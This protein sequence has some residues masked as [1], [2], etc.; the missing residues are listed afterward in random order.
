MFFMVAVLINPKSPA[1][2][3]LGLFIVSASIVFPK[4]SK[5]PSKLD[6]FFPIGFHPRPLF[7]VLLARSE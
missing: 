2:V 6:E 1:K 5:L 3:K 4:P 7:A